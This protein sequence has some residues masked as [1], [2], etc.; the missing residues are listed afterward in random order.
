MWGARG[1]GCWWP[2]WLELFE[3]RCRTPMQTVSIMTAFAK[4]ASCLRRKFERFRRRWK[5]RNR[6]LQQ[7]VVKTHEDMTLE[8][9]EDNEDEFNEGDQ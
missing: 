5:R 4:G 3:T 2:A 6:V 8:E 7:S 9:L 1:K